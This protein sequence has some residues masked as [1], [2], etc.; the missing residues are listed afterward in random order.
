MTPLLTRLA[1]EELPDMAPA[2]FAMVMATGIVAIALHNA[3]L[4]ASARGVALVGAVMW[5]CNIVLLLAR[6]ATAPRRFLADFSHA[7][8]GPGFLTLIAATEVMGSCS[9]L[10]FANAPVAR[11]FFLLGATLWP[12]LLSAILVALITT[13]NKLPLEK[14]VNGAWLLPTVS[15]QSLV[16]L[17][18]SLLAAPS[19]PLPALALLLLFLLG[20]ALYFLIM[21][22]LLYR[23]FFK[24]ISPEALS[25]T[26]WINA[27]AMAITCL[28]GVR[29]YPILTHTPELAALAPAV[30]LCTYGAWA[31]ATFWLPCLLLMGLWRHILKPYPFRYAVEYWSMV[32]PL[33]MY[34][35]CTQ[36]LQSLHP[37]WFTT[38]A[39]LSLIAAA[40]AWAI[41]LS[42]FCLSLH[43]KI[44]NKAK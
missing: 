44:R 3:G 15:T 30:A 22:L 33:G 41:V 36:A 38:P 40:T 19:S 9:L 26:F 6:T 42:A 23:L 14:S 21:P 27:G 24:H 7:G 43:S 13:D 29:L 16:V 35:V 34:T 11:L 1:R 28:A 37:F 5:F 31:L 2:N 32:F 8:R 18:A 10:L 20:I 12:V 4:P 17:G 39:R 25:A